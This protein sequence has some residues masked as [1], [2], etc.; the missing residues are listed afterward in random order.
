MWLYLEHRAKPLGI[1]GGRWL[2]VMLDP[3]RAVCGCA[4]QFLHSEDSFTDGKR[5]SMTGYAVILQP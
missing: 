1:G 4:T 5:L 2:S 3:T